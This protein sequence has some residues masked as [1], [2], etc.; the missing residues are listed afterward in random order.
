MLN[1]KKFQSTA[2]VIVL[3][4]HT[5]ETKINSNMIHR[6]ISK[7]L[8]FFCIDVVV[9]VVVVLM[10]RGMLWEDGTGGGSVAD[11]HLENEFWYVL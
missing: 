8:F 6:K 11:K 1:D 7:A 3:V 10:R 9:V 2:A 5:T 4:P